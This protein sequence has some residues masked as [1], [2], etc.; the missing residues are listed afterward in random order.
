MSTARLFH[1]G[2]G[3]PTAPLNPKAISLT[4]DT[5]LLIWNLPNSLNAPVN[6]IKYKVS[7]LI[8]TVVFLVIK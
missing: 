6:E 4:P 3:F 8:I 7:V 5:V 1:T 2:F